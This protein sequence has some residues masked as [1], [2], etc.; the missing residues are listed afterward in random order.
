V[1]TEDLEGIVMICV[2]HT[3]H[4]VDG[5]CCIH[6]CFAILKLIWTIVTLSQ[7]IPAQLLKK[8]Q[9]TANTRVSP[10]YGGSEK[11]RKFLA[12]NLYLL[13]TEGVSPLMKILLVD[14]DPAYANLLAEVLTLYSHNVVKANDGEAALGFLK[15]EQVDLVI[16]DALMPKMS[17]LELHSSIR[18]DVRLKNTP[19]ALNSAHKQLLDILK[20]SNPDVDFK[21]DKTMALPSLLYFISHMDAAQRI[22]KSSTPS[23]AVPGKP[24]KRQK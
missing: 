24:D 19:F 8:F 11:H 12:R 7:S 22:R 2:H 20:V 5:G 13:L 4:F 16:S 9:A 15:K 1:R 23:E 3:V 6:S 21:F 14:N 10:V 18:T 17:G